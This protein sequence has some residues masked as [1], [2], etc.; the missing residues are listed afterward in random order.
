METFVNILIISDNTTSSELLKLSLS[1]SDINTL[2]T[3][4]IKQALPIIDAN[5]V[6]LVLLEIPPHIGYAIQSC[7]AIRSSTMVPFIVIS[8]INDPDIVAKI[9]DAGADDYLARPFSYDILVARI[10][11]LNRRVHIYSSSPIT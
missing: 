4:S 2:V 10:N 5:V 1:M 11:K 9:L 3:S 8:T 6:D 7:E